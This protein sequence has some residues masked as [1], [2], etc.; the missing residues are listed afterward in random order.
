MS[1][2]NFAADKPRVKHLGECRAAIGVRP[3][4]HAGTDFAELLA[5]TEASSGAQPAAYAE[6]LC[7]DASATT[8]RAYPTSITPDGV[9]KLVRRYALTL[10]LKMAPS[11]A[12]RRQDRR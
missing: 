9:Y 5:T 8:S 3:Y 4:L 1:D 10:G 7:S 11:A 6:G 12:C 2:L